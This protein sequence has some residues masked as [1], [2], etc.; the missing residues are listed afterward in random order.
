M[1]AYVQGFSD[2]SDSQVAAQ[3]A[4]QQAHDQLSGAPATG[5]FAFFTDAHNAEEIGAG[6]QRVFA[7]VPLVGCTVPGVFA[8]DTV[9]HSGVVVTACADPNLSIEPILVEGVGANSRT[10]GNRVAE[11]VWAHTKDTPESHSLTLLLPDGIQGNSVEVARGVVDELGSSVQIAGGGSGDDLKFVQAHQLR[12]STVSTN[13]ALAVSFNAQHPIG[14]GLSHGCQPV[15]PPM[16]ANSVQGKELKQLDFNSAFDRFQQVATA[17][18]TS[19]DSVTSENFM[20]FAML[21]PLG[22]VQGNDEHVLRSPLFVAEENAISCCSDIPENASVRMM[23]GDAESMLEAT[24]SA[25]RTALAGIGQAE[26]SAAMIFACVSRDLVLGI[27]D[28]GLSLEIKAMREVLGP[29]VPI[30]GSLTFG[31]FGTLGSST[32]QYHS[33]SINISIFPKA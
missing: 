31:G 23:Q 10:A 1:S 3:T 32:P 21:H 27:D 12:G 30:F 33:K 16:V 13:S 9:T 29:D 18:I 22:I 24:R 4:A 2:A 6:L 26:P 17:E 5:V 8:N 7:D 19:S 15:G 25:T 14:V 20:Q 11:A 28:D